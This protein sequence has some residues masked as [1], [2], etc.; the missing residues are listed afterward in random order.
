MVSLICEQAEGRP[1]GEEVNSDLKEL[2]SDPK[3]HA[4][5]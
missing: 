5:V 2:M 3:G 1:T 4:G